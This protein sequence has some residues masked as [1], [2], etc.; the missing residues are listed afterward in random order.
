MTSL[1][2]LGAVWIIVLMAIL[3]AGFAGTEV[4][5]EGLFNASVCVLAVGVLVPFYRTRFRLED[6]PLPTIVFGCIALIGA[7]QLASGASV[8]PYVTLLETV[9]WVSFAALAFTTA[10]LAA[11]SRVRRILPDCLYGLGV[12]IVI[13]G[14][15]HFY[16][17][18][19]HLLWSMTDE[20]GPTFAPFINR[21]HFAVFCE[22]VLPF[23][24]CS[25]TG[26]RTGIAL[27]G[28]VA[29]L[30]LAAI[31]VSGSRMGVLVSSGEL[32]AILML[33]RRRLQRPAP[34]FAAASVIAVLGILFAVIGG[35][36]ILL[37][38]L[39]TPAEWQYRMMMAGS[40]AMMGTERP[41]TGHGLGTFE[42]VYPRFA[43]FDLGLRVDHAHNDW[44]EWF[45]EGGLILPLCM[46]VFVFS[47][48]RRVRER[49]WVIGIVAALLHACVDFP[50]RIPAITAY[51]IAIASAGQPLRFAASSKTL[52]KK[53]REVGEQ[54]MCSVPLFGDSSTN[55]R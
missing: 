14:L 55:P 52:V 4:W 34:L 45:A 26:G 24:V 5:A 47:V 3:T 54:P 8:Y 29:A 44:L 25:A 12:V 7:L 48:L 15:L 11:D 13:F 31:F 28:S 6:L 51:A 49:P 2:L 43:Q 32:I 30:L 21:D 40:A 37:R 42:V 38:K 1:R 19:G 16:T 22:L 17:C 10:Y 33:Q 41:F 50:W 39:R 9:R 20:F 35:P 46:A 27:H 23:A 36:D 18:G 53:S